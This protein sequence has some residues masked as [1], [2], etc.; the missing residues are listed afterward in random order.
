MDPS[1]RVADDGEIRLIQ[2][3]ALSDLLEEGYA[4]GDEE[5]IAC[6]EYF[7]SG[8]DDTQA[9]DKLLRLA[10]A[11]QS[12]PWPDAWLKERGEDYAGC[13]DLDSF[14]G[15]AVATELMERIRRELRDAARELGELRRI[16][17]EPDGPYV[18]AE[19]IQSE[20]E[21]LT[22]LCERVMVTGVTGFDDIYDSMQAIE[23]GRLT[24]KKDETIDP[25]KREYVRL[26]RA[27]IKDR[28][29]E[30]KKELFSVP[31]SE[32]LEQAA[33]AE[34]PV[35]TLCSLA[36]RFLVLFSEKK[37]ERAVIDFSDME[38]LALEILLDREVAEDGSVRVRPSDVAL[39]YRQSFREIMVD[40]YQDS[41]AVQELLL[42][43]IAGEPQEQGEGRERCSRFMVGDVKQSIYRFRQARPEIFLEKYSESAPVDIPADADDTG[44][45]SLSYPGQHRRIDLHRNFRSRP[46]VVDAVN[47]VFGRI[48]R[49]DLGGVEYDNDA[50]LICGRDVT[51]DADHRA[52]LLL[53][54]TDIPEDADGAEDIEPDIRRR[55]ALMVA[56][57]IKRVIS[58][59][60]VPV[61]APDGTPSD[62]PARYSDIVILLRTMKGWD[63]TFRDVLTGQ[64]IP[65]AVETG[66]G[67]FSAMEVVLLLQVLSILDDPMQDIAL[68]AVMR[69]VFGGFTDEELSRIRIYDRRETGRIDTEEAAEAGAAVE[70]PADDQSR[71]R[72]RLTG[73]YGA[74]VRFSQ[75]GEKGHEAHALAGQ[76]RDT[77]GA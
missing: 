5:F 52:E 35:R 39:G 42:S 6:M 44:M 55:E 26:S 12:M 53:L 50:A 15:T 58:E 24:S 28:V 70:A 11:A 61:S 22:G 23:F 9:A 74:L 21:A 10:E 71:E 16:C 72:V 73:Y 13:A 20:E 18:Y 64:D 59:L 60:R 63:D 32:A 66:T 25:E 65:V 45:R 47:H 37:R 14:A 62:R 8:A 7:S 67:Y 51:A 57:R 48:M 2:Q 36:R 3:E 38:H 17:E 4:S 30:L 19:L 75:S 33:R 54:E 31:L 56:Q 29:G 77:T 41:N 1:S 76:S 68:A 49:A 69:S 34:A 40:E 46:E 43:S 27:G